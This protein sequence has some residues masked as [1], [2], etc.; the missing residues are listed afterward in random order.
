MS[1]NYIKPFL[2]WPGGKLRVLQHIH[3]ALPAGKRLVEPFVGSGAVFLNS[4]YPSF[5]LSDINP[6]L[7]N[8]YKLLQKRG[9]HFI[10]QSKRYFTQQYNNET[11]YYRLR[12][13][14]NRCRD[15]EK[16]SI[17]FLYLNRHAYNG[18][19]RYN[20]KGEF[21][22]P[23]GR[24]KKTY[25]PELEL[26]HFIK[27]AKYA[28]FSCLPFEELLKK[29]QAGDVIYCDPPYSPL[30]SR[31]NFTNYTGQSF[32][33][34]AHEQLA[35]EAKKMVAQ[36]LPMIISNHDTPQTRKLYESASIKGFKVQRFISCLGNERKQV[37]E[38]LAIY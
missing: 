13:Q 2:K 12:A 37:K 34:Q 32:N 16:R 15:L 24:Y 21:N 30:N 22:V 10:R 33:L 36:K 27:K 14:F 6:D 23:F 1:T 5:L 11:Q 28:K 35:K 26:R 18:L 38:L 25:F 8:L 20:K 17:L 31:A 9:E 4:H 7:I 3:P 19:C 29:T